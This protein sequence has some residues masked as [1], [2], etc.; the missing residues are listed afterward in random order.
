MYPD[1]LPS[2]PAIVAGATVTHRW[3]SSVITMQVITCDTT[4][5]TDETATMTSVAAQRA[6]H[7]DRRQQIRVH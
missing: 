5:S 4:A 7:R 6:A 1:L 2:V 3:G